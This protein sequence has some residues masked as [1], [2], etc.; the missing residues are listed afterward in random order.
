MNTDKLRALQL[1]LEWL[2]FYDALY[3]RMTDLEYEQAI[4]DTKYK[5]AIE[6]VRLGR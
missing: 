6:L 3:F 1:R 4:D 5:I 2:L